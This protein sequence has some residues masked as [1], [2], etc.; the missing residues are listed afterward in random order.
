MILVQKHYSIWRLHTGWYLLY[1]FNMIQLIFMDL[2]WII[3]SIC[4]TPVLH[5]FPG[6]KQ[7]T[8][9]LH[10]SLAALLF[11]LKTFLLFEFCF[12]GQRKE[13]FTSGRN[14]NNPSCIQMALQEEKMKQ[15][16]QPA[17]PAFDYVIS[18]MHEYSWTFPTD[19]GIVGRISCNNN[20]ITAAAWKWQNLT[21]SYTS[22]MVSVKPTRGEQRSSR[23]ANA[24]RAW[25][26][27]Y[28]TNNTAVSQTWS[29][30][31]TFHSGIY[32][33]VFNLILLQWGDVIMIV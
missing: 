11:R 13:S 4:V 1:S 20:E 22:R 14:T 8:Q 27:T 19:N 9:S 26:A 21:F 30:M 31:R 3:F 32:C 7:C 17:T 33:C 15:S 25:M 24:H 18:P 2:F 29:N 16:L 12:T 5:Q 10:W 6:N 28:V 23:R